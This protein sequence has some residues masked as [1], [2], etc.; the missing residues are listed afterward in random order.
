[1][2]LKNVS[3]IL[4][5]EI[6]LETK[7]LQ[8]PI[9]N[10]SN[11]KSK[12]SIIITIRDYKF[13]GVKAQSNTITMV[14]K[15]LKQLQKNKNP[16][17]RHCLIDNMICTLRWLIRL[18]YSQTKNNCNAIEQVRHTKPIFNKLLRNCQRT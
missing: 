12:A 7:T 3:K 18:K 10:L 9:S 14:E 13:N 8:Q 4:Q 1:M 5:R 2:Y 16:A 15:L 11:F 6:Y 17:M